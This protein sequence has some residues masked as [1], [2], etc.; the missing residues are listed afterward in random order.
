MQKSYNSVFSRDGAVSGMCAQWS[1][2]LARAYTKFLKNESADIGKKLAAGGNA[3]QNNEFF[4]NLTKLG[5]VKSVSTGLTRERCIKKI[6]EQ[7]WG[8]GDVCVYYANDKPTSGKISHYQ[9]GHAQIYV[10]EINSTG[11]ATSTQTNYGTDMVYK[12]RKSNNW[13]LLTFRAPES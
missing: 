10:G 6:E 5:Y 13:D 1:Y 8:Y 2:N 3:N 9:Y 4:N 12:G 11:W 7:T